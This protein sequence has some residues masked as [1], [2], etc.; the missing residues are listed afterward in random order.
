MTKDMDIQVVDYD[1]RLLEYLRDFSDD[2]VDMPEDRIAAI[3]DNNLA[4]KAW[5]SAKGWVGSGSAWGCNI[6]GVSMDCVGSAIALVIDCGLV[7]LPAGMRQS[8]GAAHSRAGELEKSAGELNRRLQAFLMYILMRYTKPGYIVIPVVNPQEIF[9]LDIFITP[10]T[11]SIN[12]KVMLPH[13][14]ICVRKQQF[15]TA[16]QDVGMMQFVNVEDGMHIAA[17]ISDFGDQEEP[18]AGFALRFYAGAPD[19]MYIY[20]KE[21]IVSLARQYN[22]ELKGA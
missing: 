7:N 3:S 1:R 2:Y 6:P 18:V 11:L 20:H 16:N 14:M 12:G 15:L 5:R 17:D 22:K 4:I 21:R 8:F 19:P 9:P 10:F 13:A